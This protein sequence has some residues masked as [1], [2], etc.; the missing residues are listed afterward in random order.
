[1]RSRYIHAGVGGLFYAESCKMFKGCIVC[2][3]A[4]ESGRT[5]SINCADRNKQSL[6]SIKHLMLSAWNLLLLSCAECLPRHV[7]KVYFLKESSFQRFVGLF[8]GNEY[9][10]MPETPYFHFI[11]SVSSSLDGLLESF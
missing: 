11:D 2:L 7:L 10:I 6:P 8:I 1:M 3:L 9:H 4:D 5:S